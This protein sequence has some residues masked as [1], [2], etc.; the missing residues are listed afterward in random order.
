[1]SWLSISS[2]LRENDIGGIKTGTTQLFL[3]ASA[4]SNWSIGI[5]WNTY[6][7]ETLIKGHLHSVFK[8][9]WM[10]SDW[11]LLKFWMSLTSSVPRKTGRKIIVT[12]Q[13]HRKV[14]A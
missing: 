5:S 4:S 14:T 13:W 9:G 7:C 12:A 3:W 2:F 1:M 8:L 6:Q 11:V 10:I